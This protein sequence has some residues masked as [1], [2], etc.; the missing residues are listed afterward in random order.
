MLIYVLKFCNK[1]L[2]YVKV[3]EIIDSWF[4]FFQMSLICVEYL[5]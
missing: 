4:F 2:M 3:F 5:P 1:I